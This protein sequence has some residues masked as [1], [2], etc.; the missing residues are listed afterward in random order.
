[1]INVLLVLRLQGIDEASERKNP[2]C[3]FV[4]RERFA[5]LKNQLRRVVGQE[6]GY[7]ETLLPTIIIAPMQTNRCQF[8]GLYVQQHFF[9]LALLKGF[10]PVKMH[11]FIVIR[12]LPVRQLV[13][14]W[15]VFQFIQEVVDGLGL[16]E[17]ADLPLIL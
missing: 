4:L 3:T 1:M 9:Q 12:V 16:A 14:N 13:T 11:K 5:D 10:L 15:L 8:S 6:L 17:S 7:I 2:I